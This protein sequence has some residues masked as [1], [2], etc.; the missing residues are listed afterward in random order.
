MINDIL[1]FSK[2]EAGKLVLDC[3]PFDLREHLG[4][5]MKTLA[6]RADRKGIELL[7]HVHPDVP[8]V[9]VGDGARLRQVL[10]NL[11]GNAIKFTEV[12]EVVVEVDARVALPG[13]EIL[14]HFK[15]ADTGIGIPAEKQAV[16]F[17]AFEQ[18]DG[19]HLPPLRRD[20]PGTG[21]LLA[22]G[23]AAGR[24][25]LDGKPG[26]PRQHVSLQHALPDAAAEEPLP[27]GSRA[28]AGRVRDA[29]VLVVDDNAT[30][31]RSWKKCWATGRCNPP[32][33]RAEQEALRAAAAGTAGGPSVSPGGDR[34]PHAGDGRLLAGRTDQGRPQPGQHGDH[35]A[36]LGDQP[37]DVGRC[38]ELGITTFLLK[39]VKQSEL[40]D[41]IMLAHGD[42]HGRRR[43]L[44]R[45]PRNRIRD[46]DR[47]STVER[48][49]PRTAGGQRLIGKTCSASI[50]RGRQPWTN[51]ARPMA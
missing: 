47:L 28:A 36:H 27:P 16:V 34:C 51:V 1:D 6:L 33:R 12:G 37:A 43:S 8:D 38:Q 42:H 29:K 49:G 39:P 11:V 20:R 50:G 23:R 45:F 10:I 7:C 22:P 18:A 21:H 40:L 24:A 19:D 9:V 30:N 13:D 25:D 4:D 31:R 15:V 44:R 46:R 5:T 2:I 41:A 17:E 32:R 26:R 35:D 48:R 3:H 14:L